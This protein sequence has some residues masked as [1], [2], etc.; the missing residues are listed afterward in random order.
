MTP[1]ELRDGLIRITQALYSEACD[2][3]AAQTFFRTTDE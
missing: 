3:A 1:T 2:H